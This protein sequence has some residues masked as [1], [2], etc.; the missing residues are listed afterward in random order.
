MLN[1]IEISIIIATRNR[2]K[3]LWET[4]EKACAAIKGKNAEIII[5][6]DG[7]APLEIPETVAGKINLI[8]NPK[9]GVAVARNT[10]A[11]SAKGNIL[12][13]ADD[14]MWINSQVIDWINSNLGSKNNIQSVFCIN[15]EYPPY[16]KEKLS[17]SKIGRYILAANYH[18]LWGRL[19]EKNPQPSGLFEHVYLGSGSFVIHQSL[20]KKTGGYNESM[21]FQGEDDDLAERLRKLGIKSYLVFNTT[22]YHNQIDRLEIKA[23]L[24][25]I[26]DGF[27]SEFYAE[28]KGAAIPAKQI[29]YNSFQKL[30]FE[31]SRITEKIWISFL[32]ILPN[33]SLVTPLNNK[34]IGALGGLQRY[35][36]WRKIIG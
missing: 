8:E 36:Q 15:W 22:L 3:I 29:N 18:T 12:F 9:R 30:I 10:G 21:I 32:N 20:F 14:D 23:F 17:E 25:R 26:Y 35:K 1:N 27:G 2:E 34:L 33:H 4:V 31:I 11:A 6:N 7:A 24:K 13:F 16:L 19:H 28:K 5:V